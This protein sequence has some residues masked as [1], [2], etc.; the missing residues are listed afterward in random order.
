MAQHGSGHSVPYLVCSAQSG[1]RTWDDL[2][3][4]TSWWHLTV[5]WLIQRNVNSQFLQGEK[6]S[7]KWR[8]S[9]SVWDVKNK[10]WYYHRREN[11]DL[12]LL[13]NPD[14][15]LICAF[16]FLWY[17]SCGKSQFRCFKTWLLSCS[18]VSDSGPI[19]SSP[20]GFSV[21]GD[22]PG[23]NTRVGGHALLQGIF[24]TQDQTQV[25]RI[26]GRFFTKWD[27]REALKHD[28][29][30]GFLSRKITSLFPDVISSRKRKN[31]P[32]TPCMYLFLRV[33]KS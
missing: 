3:S 14:W 1:Y 16:F 12:L 32:Q 18:V 25:S 6:T 26:A 2:H 30:K 21:H 29:V 11:I 10:Q 5:C 13:V 9:W 33:L 23:K 7:Y 24:P 4:P 20:P 28:W 31:V 19:G 8:S 17:D 15:V 22:C 27:T